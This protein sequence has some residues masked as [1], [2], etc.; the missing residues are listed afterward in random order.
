MTISITDPAVEAAIRERVQSGAFADA[1][2]VV[3][4]ALAP[5]SP[6]EGLKPQSSDVEALT[7]DEL[8]APL[9]GLNIEFGRNPSTSRPTSL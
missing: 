1:E 5:E 2:D 9:R 7:I 8:F 4:S 6:G 3:R